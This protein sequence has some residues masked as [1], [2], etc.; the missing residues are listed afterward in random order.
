MLSQEITFEINELVPNY[1][2]IYEEIDTNDNNIIEGNKPLCYNELGSFYFEIENNL[3]SSP[4][5]YYLNDKEIFLDGQIK[6]DGVGYLITDLELDKH[7][8]TIIDDQGAC[9]TIDFE[10]LN[11][12]NKTL[13]KDVYSYVEQRILCADDQVDTNLNLG[14]IDVTDQIVGGQ[15]FNRRF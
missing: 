13:D 2:F 4:L 3:S 7:E 5:R 6:N 8:F 9:Y 15:L 1:E 14:I 12:E 11:N 10:I